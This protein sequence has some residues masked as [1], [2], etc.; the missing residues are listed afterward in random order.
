MKDPERI[1]IIPEMTVDG[2][3]Y[4][5]CYDS[6]HYE[7]RIEREGIPYVLERKEETTTEPIDAESITTLD[8][9]VVSECP[10][11]CVATFEAMVAR[12]EFLEAERNSMGQ[13]FI[14]DVEEVKD[15]LDK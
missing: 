14:D 12:L 2:P 10:T 4:K 13:E 7:E 15:Q 6:R 1:W 5:L 11:G 3:S 9:F 8:H